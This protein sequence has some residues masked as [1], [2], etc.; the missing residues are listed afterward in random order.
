[1]SA[2]SLERPVRNRDQQ[3]LIWSRRRG[4]EQHLPRR[5]LMKR[6]SAD[7][8]TGAT[9]PI[10]SRRNFMRVAAASGGAGLVSAGLLPIIVQARTASPSQVVPPPATPEIA[11][12]KVHVPQAALE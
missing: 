11:P 1:K 6:D 3:P 2:E 8:A 9:R 12:F 5:R 10:C 7:S 4:N